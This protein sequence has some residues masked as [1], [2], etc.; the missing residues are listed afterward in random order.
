MAESQ[1]AGL[2]MTPE[3]YRQQQAQANRMRAME[4]AQMAP[5]QRAAMGFYSAG[6]GLGQLAGSL[7]GAQDP[8]LQR[9][10]EQQRLLQGLDV[11]DPDSLMQAARQASQA[12]NVPLAMQLAQRAQ[13]VAQ[14]LATTQKAQLSLQQ[15]RALR[16]ELAAL[17][18]DATDEQRIAILSKYG[19]P[20]QMLQALTTQV[21][22]REALESR[23]REAT[24]RIEARR[25][26]LELQLQNRLDVAA[27]QGATQQAIAKMQI[28]GRQQIAQMMGD[29]RREVAAS[30]GAGGGGTP[31]FQPVQT[32]QGVFAFNAR[33]GQ[34][35][36]ISGPSGAPIV[37]ASADPT[38]QG[39]IAGARAGATVIGKSR[40]EAAIDAPRVIA[41]GEEAIRLVDD[42]LKSPGL[43]QA[44]GTSRLVQ[45]QRVPGTPARDFDIRLEQLKGQQFLQAYETLKGG[46]HITEV[47]GKKATD[48]ISRMDA[49]STEKEFTNAA[50]E[51]QNAI[52]AGIERARKAQAQGQTPVPASAQPSA[53]SGRRRI[54]FDAQGNVI[55]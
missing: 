17:P 48:A 35:D 3:M 38:L 50:R 43:K 5:E 51:F 31:Y 16:N 8:Q 36:P 21:G 2:F 30:R 22:R 15:E 39:N 24:Q 41:Q 40:A 7:L 18:P 42:L 10:T 12:G 44:V 47:E 45:L 52:R 19:P 27:A 55:K 53:A 11:A 25:Q 13:E 49:S 20:G 29:V 26:D 1:I 14:G 46:G 37:G 54:R 23:E 32:A 34:M 28:D 33:T 9:I 4:Y 6:Q